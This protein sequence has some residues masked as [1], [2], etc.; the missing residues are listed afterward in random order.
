MLKFIE[1][2][3]LIEE[4]QNLKKDSDGADLAVAFWGNG[5]AARLKIKKNGGIRIICNLQSGACNPDEIEKLQRLVNIRTHKELHAKVYSTKRGAI[6]GS[7]N[8]STNGLA[9]PASDAQWWREANIVVDDQSI[10][11]EIAKWFEIMW[12]EAQEITESH[13]GRARE[14]WKLRFSK[15]P[16]RT[17]E[18]T[19]I[20]V[21]KANAELLQSAEIYCIVY[22]DDLD[23]G[24]K[25]AWK[26]L[27]SGAELAKAWSYQPI[28]P[29]KAGSWLISC[30]F[31]KGSP[32]INGYLHVPDELASYLSSTKGEP[33]LYAAY[34]K[35]GIEVGLVCYPLSKGEKADLL[36]KLQENRRF[37]R[38]NKT[39]E[40]GDALIPLRDLI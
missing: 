13:L 26:T 33:D 3:R 19:L 17:N 14:L 29:F 31:R 25:A 10:L 40:W 16:H 20:A 39:W 4:F 36:K 9:I 7:S 6:I 5:S 11:D 32:S 27:S 30:N 34:P 8:A 1:G 22:R 38:L 37:K 24:A 12:R 15:A 23:P 2:G 21:L 35:S 18:K 28:E